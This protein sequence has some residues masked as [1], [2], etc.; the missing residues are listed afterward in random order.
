MRNISWIQEWSRNTHVWRWWWWWLWSSTTSSSVCFWPVLQRANW[1]QCW[2]LPKHHVLSNHQHF[3]YQCSMCLSPLTFCAFVYYIKDNTDQL[4]MWND[5]SQHDAD[6]WLDI[7]LV[8]LIF[9]NAV[10]SSAFW[11]NLIGHCV[12]RPECNVE[13]FKVLQLSEVSKMWRR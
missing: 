11:S 1:R 13:F 6:K 7:T 4:V 5:F 2:I 8:E 10:F 9:K 3:F 12:P